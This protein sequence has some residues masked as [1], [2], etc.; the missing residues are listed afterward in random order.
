MSRDNAVNWHWLS[1]A[2][3]HYRP[4][5]A[6]AHPDGPAGVA[7]WPFHFTYSPFGLLRPQPSID[8]GCHTLVTDLRRQN[9]NI[10]LLGPRKTRKDAALKRKQ[11]RHSRNENIITISVPQL[12]W[13][14]YLKLET[15]RRIARYE[16]KQRIDEQGNSSARIKTTSEGRPHW[17][18]SEIFGRIVNALKEKQR[19]N[20]PAGPPSLQHWQPE[21]WRVLRPEKKVCRVR[22]WDHGRTASDERQYC[23]SWTARWKRR[24]G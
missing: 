2:W 9:K 6:M 19:Y 11:R 10:V 12:W 8:Y 3:I 1:D 16:E 4:H 24:T 14:K 21:W 15:T 5:H 13:D 20:Q 18:I 22:E 17:T 7:R 23:L